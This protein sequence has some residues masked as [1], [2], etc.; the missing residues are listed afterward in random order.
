MFKNQKQA[1]Q[2]QAPRIKLNNKTETKGVLFQIDDDRLVEN[3]PRFLGSVDIG[4]VKM[5]LSAFLKQAQSS[6][7]EYLDLSFGDKGQP[8]Y[9]GRLFKNEKR[10]PKSPDYRGYITLLELDPDIRNQYDRDDWDNADR[11]T[12]FGRRVRNAD[13][14]VRIALDILPVRQPVAAGELAF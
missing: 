7:T 11:L 12:V 9:S 4:N 1:P 3:G 5:S 6:D 14:G 8:H 10:G 2:K 13:G